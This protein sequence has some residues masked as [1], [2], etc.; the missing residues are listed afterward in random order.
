MDTRERERRARS[1]RSLARGIVPEKPEMRRSF[2]PRTVERDG[3]KA[4]RG[5]GVA[6]D[7]RRGARSLPPRRWPSSLRSMIVIPAESR[8][9][10]IDTRPRLSRESQ[11]RCK[12]AKAAVTSGSTEGRRGEGGG[13]VARVAVLEIPRQSRGIKSPEKRI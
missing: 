1:A 7:S 9:A 2:V 8:T 13:V 10:P 11:G 5:N 3:G 6:E 4:E 12:R